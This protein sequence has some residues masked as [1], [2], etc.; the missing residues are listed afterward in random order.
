[1]SISRQ[2]NS[3]CCDCSRQIQV[4]CSRGNTCSKKSGTTLTKGTI[5]RLI[6]TLIVCV[7]RSKRTRRNRN[8]C[9]PSGAS[10]INSQTLN[11]QSRRLDLRG[12]ALNSKGDHCPSRRESLPTNGES[13]AK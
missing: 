10:V 12:I 9:L 5:E 3:T 2:K 6:L 8:W 1:M 13:H 11:R 4:E 7:P